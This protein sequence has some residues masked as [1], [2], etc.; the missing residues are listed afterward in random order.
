MIVPLLG[1]L[2]INEMN[3]LQYMEVNVQGIT[4]TAC[5]DFKLENSLITSALLGSLK[6]QKNEIKWGEALIPIDGAYRVTKGFLKECKFNL[7]D[8]TMEYP[9]YVILEEEKYIVIGKDWLEE[10]QAKITKKGTMKYLR[11]SYKKDKKY[12]S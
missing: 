7:L 8:I 3:E 6:C 10:Y 1:R 12:K 4:V 9:M 5:I 11:I 2:M